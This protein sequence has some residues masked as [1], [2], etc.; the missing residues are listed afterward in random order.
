MFSSPVFAAGIF[1]ITAVTAQAVVGNAGGA[2]TTMQPVAFEWQPV[3]EPIV[4]MPDPIIQNVF[5]QPLQNLIDSFAIAFETAPEP[6]Q[7]P[8]YTQPV[9]TPTFTDQLSDAILHTL[10][11]ASDAFII[12]PASI[13]SSITDRWFGV[14]VAVSTQP[15]TQKQVTVPAVST[16]TNFSAYVTQSFLSAQ[17]QKLKNALEAEITKATPSNTPYSDAGVQ[18]QIASLWTAL[19]LTNRID[20]ISNVVI[21]NS[22]VEAAS[23]PSLSAIS[24]L[25]GIGQGGI[26]TSTAPTYGQL[27]VGNSAGGYDLVATSSLGISGTV[28]NNPTFSSLTVTG[29]TTLAD[30]TTTNLGVT[31]TASTTRLFGAALTTCNSG[32]VLTWSGGLF[33]CATD[34]TSAGGASPFTW[35][36]NYSVIAAATTSPLWAQSGLFASSTSHFAAADFMTASS[37]TLF[38]TGSTT[39]TGAFNAVGGA[40]FGTLV[41]SGL[42]TVTGFL[43]SASST[44]N[45]TLGVTGNTNTTG[46]AS[47]TNLTI[48]SIASG[49]ILKTTTA[50]SVTSAAAGVDFATPAQAFNFTPT[51][52]YGVNTSATT[53]ALFAQAGLF[54]SSTS[55]FDQINVGSSTVSQMATSTF[56][57]NLSIRGAASTTNLFV[58]SVVTGSLLKVTTAGSVI[59]AAAGVDF[60]TVAGA[61]DFTPTSNYAVNTS[62]TSTAVWARLGLFASST[63]NFDQIN[64]GSSTTSTIATSTFF[65]NLSVRGSASTTNL[66]VSS[67]VS[68]SLLKVTTAGSVIAAV[69]GS[70]FATAAQAFNFTPT[71]NYAVNTSATTTALFAQAGLF[72]SSTSNFDIINIGSSTVSTL[73]TSTFFG[74][75]SVRGAASTTNLFVSSVVTGSLLKAT[76]AGSIIA[77]IAG[78]DYATAAQAFNFTPDYQLRG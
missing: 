19:S 25:L 5:G 39:V 75:L 49:N 12:Q 51:T 42:A 68:G 33:G 59:A 77:A 21:T 58:S 24:G 3:P 71:T 56:F 50:G 44:V 28:S 61:F 14:G 67:V 8:V 45:G 66:F 23:V 27:L 26:A 52:N 41:S 74:N 29:N 48:S 16:A 64:V 43:S 1:L 15:K 46:I 47:S 11:L 65:G 9:P 70:D 53:T 37:T 60:A 78:T 55:N 62:A 38:S 20:K 7:L 17:L 13:A 76:T 72:A 36:S 10:D 31:G 34:Q 32:N 40:T 18:G 22:T 30:A 54:A 2:L 6:P 57:G 63:S 69:A 35:T 73:A 4:D